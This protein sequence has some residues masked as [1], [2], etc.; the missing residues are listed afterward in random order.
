MNVD[1]PPH[2]LAAMASATGTTLTKI[3]LEKK[4]PTAHQSKKK[5]ES[6][7]VYSEYQPPL[8]CLHPG[9]NREP[10]IP[11][12]KLIDGRDVKAD[13]RIKSKFK[14]WP[15]VHQSVFYVD[16]GK[17]VFRDIHVRIFVVS[18]NTESLMFVRP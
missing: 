14:Q 4:T 11:L 1:L 5:Q 10:T 18:F 16:N 17:F 12:V 7:P 8:W 9:D 2:L 3:I 15:Q 6:D 13:E